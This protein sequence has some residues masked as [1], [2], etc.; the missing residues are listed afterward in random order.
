MLTSSGEGET[1]FL[2]LRWLLIG[3]LGVTLAAHGCA[4]EETENNDDNG[5]S[6]A[7]APTARVPG[8]RCL[9]DA[10]CAY[11]GGICLLGMCAKRAAGPC[12]GPNTDAGC[13]PGFKCFNTEVIPGTGV[14]LPPYDEATCELVENRFNLCSPTRVDSCDPACGAGCTPAVVAPGG[15]GAACTADAEC[16]FHAEAAC[17]QGSGGVVAWDS[18]Y[19]LMFGCADDAACGGPEAGC[20]PL[21]TDG[22]GVCMDRCGWDL[23]CRTGYR[24]RELEELP[25]ETMCMAGCDAAASCAPGFACA[26]GNCVPEDVVCTPTNLGGWCPEGSWCDAGTCNDEPFSC[27]GSDDTFEPNDALADAKDAPA[28]LTGGLALCE[29]NEDWW[30]IN[31][32]AGKIVRVGIEFMHAA[33]DLDLVAYDASGNLIGSRIG[34]LYP[35]GYRDQ[36]T[37]TEYYGFWAESTAATYHVRVLGADNG[38]TVTAGGPIENAYTLHVDEFDYSD[39]ESCTGAGWTFDE[40]AGLGPAGSGLLPFPFPDPAG[41]TGAENYQWDTFTNYRFARRELIMLV[42]HALKETSEAFPGTTPLGLIDTCQIDGITPGYDVDDPRHPE[43]THDQ[44]GNQDLAYF[45]TDGDNSSE[46]ICG[47]G[48]QHADGFCSPAATMMHKV[49]LPRQAFFMAALFRSPRLRVIGVDKIIA[50]L[51]SD[52]ATQL[53]MLPDTDPQ[54]ITASD[55]SNFGSGMAYGDGWPF[56]HH[57][58]HLSMQWWSAAD[59]TAA[60]QGGEPSATDHGVFGRGVPERS[61]SRHS[62]QHPRSLRAA[63]AVS[64][65]AAKDWNKLEMSWPPV[66]AQPALPQPR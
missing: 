6:G 42:R 54:H 17:Y 21:A 50:P 64:L 15:A 46:V 32:P 39:A 4:S 13:D 57:H 10:D 16:A 45:Q 2:K 26:G 43:T 18:G 11:D 33:G 29:G 23:D 51:I 60:A 7:N 37:D 25:G 5:G 3:T 31:V 49:D 9:C 65:E 19:C 12:Q 52:A 62:M 56:H 36:E 53:N 59:Y 44:G 24:C 35:Y 30:R 14:C 61:G 27:G 22:S 38:G 66:P 34:A 48:S 63:S 58:I 47:D 41:A 8:A 55:L 1:M 28:G 40:C 20:F